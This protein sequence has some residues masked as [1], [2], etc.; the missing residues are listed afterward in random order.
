MRKVTDGNAVIGQFVIEEGSVRGSSVCRAGSE[1]AV[2]VPRNVMTVTN[3]TS[4]A[5]TF[6]SLLFQYGRVHCF[7]SVLR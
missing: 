3:G 1:S 6:R 7:L 5:V 2:A 4:M